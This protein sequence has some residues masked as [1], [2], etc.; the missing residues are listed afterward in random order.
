MRFY[1]NGS[2]KD[3]KNLD[4]STIYYNDEAERRYIGT[5][6]DDEAWSGDLGLGGS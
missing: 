1:I 4:A 2:Y 5:A 6:D 3:N